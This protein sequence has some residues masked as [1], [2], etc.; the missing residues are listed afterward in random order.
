MPSVVLLL[1]AFAYA[2]VLSGEITVPPATTTADA[3][4][5]LTSVSNSSEPAR[6]CS[7]ET[8]N[9]VFYPKTRACTEARVPC[10][11]QENV[12]GIVV[13]YCSCKTTIWET[14][15]TA[16][17]THKWVSEL[18]SAIE[19]G[20]PAE[21][22]SKKMASSLE[23]TLSRQL[24]GGDITKSVQLSVALLGLARTQFDGVDKYDQ[25]ARATNFAK[26]FGL[27]GN[28]L[29]SQQALKAWEELTPSLIKDNAN[30]L[31]SLL[32]QSVLTLGD[33]ILDPQKKLQYDNWAMKIDF[34]QWE[35]TSRKDSTDL[36][37]DITSLGPSVKG[38]INAVPLTP[39]GQLEEL[40]GNSTTATPSRAPRV[41]F[42]G[43]SESPIIELPP[44][45]HLD[46]T[47]S[48]TNESSAPV[49]AVSRVGSK[50]G[51][52]S[53]YTHLRL[54]YLV[55]KNLGQLLYVNKFTMVNSHIACVY[56]GDGTK[57]I[58]LLHD[59]PITLTF[60]HLRRRLVNPTCISLNFDTR[61]LSVKGCR[62][63]STSWEKTECA[64]THLGSCFAVLMKIAVGD[65]IWYNIGKDIKLPFDFENIGRALSAVC[66][67]F[68]LF[69]FTFFRSLHSVRNTIHW[70]L[71]F[72]L[73]VHDLVFSISLPR[74][75]N[76][77][78]CAIVM[79]LDPY[80]DIAAFCWMLTEGYQL[81]LSLVQ[82][83]DSNKTRLLP[84]CVFSYGFPAVVVGVVF[85]W[86]GYESKQYCSWFNLSLR[87][88][89]ALFVPD[90]II[91][92]ANVIILVIALR[93][94]LTLNDR[95]R[96]RKDK[97]FRWLKRLATLMCLLG[98]THLF[99]F[100]SLYFPWTFPWTVFDWMHAVFNS[101]QGVFIFILLVILNENVRSP[102][103][104]YLRN[105]INSIK[106]SSVVTTFGEKRGIRP[107]SLLQFSRNSNPKAEEPRLLRYE[108]ITAG[109]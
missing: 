46:T 99:F 71:C 72:S 13:R 74:I 27:C 50:T 68:S 15:N 63:I 25:E 37:A 81:Y 69:V 82:V 51:A 58:N 19:K 11:D 73:L 44:L 30:V 104:R 80:S 87:V 105:K 79:M 98:V 64:C 21:Q 38:K 24:Y 86:D 55:F 62:L 41:E 49:S 108:R 91:I 16:N 31:T 54:S 2:F 4:T 78:C 59:Q 8:R 52:A 39:S 36:A 89:L 34:I 65:A 96:S 94:L 14:P 56:V 17:C 22:I 67:A 12:E 70:N 26:S 32:K 10:S 77:V 76:R 48:S 33:Y 3:P 75:R 35:D 84:Y 40:A 9:G 29:L 53:S 92:L 107:L 100:L 66:L 23:Y 18:E 28:Y 83:F 60:F 109:F 45:S 93:V 42:S 20:D 6:Y 103:I 43:F 85:S 1:T 101:L 95:D 47:E 90:F 7:A 57:S 106:S 102:V 61:M 97:L 88:H 5:S